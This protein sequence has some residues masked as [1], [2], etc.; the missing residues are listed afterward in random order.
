MKRLVFIAVITV[1]LSSVAQKPHEYKI[2]ATYHIASPGGWDYIAVHNGKLYV[3]HG[4]QV[5]ILNEATG[6]SVGVIPNTAG[7][8]GIAFDDALGR[9]YTSNGR[10]NNVTVFDAKTTAILAQIETGENPDAILFEPFTKTIIT[11]NGRSKNLSLIDPV[12]QKVIATIAV[13]GKPETAVSSEKGMLFVNIEDKNEIVAVDL[14]TKTVV[15]HWSLNGA[16]GPTGLVYDKRTRR[17]FAGCEKQLVVLN[18]E[19]GKVINHLPIG[20]GCD[21]V[22]FNSNANL[23]FTSNGADGN[24]TVIK[25]EGGDRYKVLGNYATKRGGRTITIDQKDGTLFIPTA[26]FEAGQTSNGRP[27]IVPG[28]FQVLVVK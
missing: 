21:G 7:V 24:M 10:S 19:T 6:D 4:T 5:N 13:G 25:E 27:K 11:C 22:S 17:L 28:S 20:D 12:A 18:A 15:H 14:K 23:I 16:E 3:T 8:H 1:S 9:G 26:D 2:A